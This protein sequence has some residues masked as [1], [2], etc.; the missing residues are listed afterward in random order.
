MTSDLSDKLRVYLIEDT[1]DLRDE[2][3]FGLSALGL[4]VTGFGEAAGLYR[5]LA[6]SPC[7]IVLID[8]GLP[9]EDGFSIGRHLRANRALGLV[10]LSA[11]AS[12]EDRLQGLELGADAYLV[13]PVDVRELA[14]TLHAVHRR[15]QANPAAPQ[16]APTPARWRLGPDDWTLRN[17]QG[18]E[19]NVSD[20]ERRFLKIM[21]PA[22][23][24][25]VARETLINAFA[26]DVDDYDPHRLDA[27]IS[28]L[29]KRAEQAGLGSL[30]LL[31]V[32]GT[33]YVFNA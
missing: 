23:G 16:A 13:K 30:P 31:S 32:R 29:R 11:R 3:V 12:L 20:S 10:Y 18:Q 25:V 7:D 1:T 9:G 17:P 26:Q 14:A 6:A 15:L 2:M 19:L 27:V 28:R 24:Q 33:G 4:D 22:A 5:A 21:L 8:V